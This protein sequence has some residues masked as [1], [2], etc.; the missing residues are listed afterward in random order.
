ML[1]WALTNDKFNK[2]LETEMEWNSHLLSDL[3]VHK[4]T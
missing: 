1:Y 3:S 4:Y 2:K